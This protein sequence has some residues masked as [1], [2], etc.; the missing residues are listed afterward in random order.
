MI[1]LTKVKEK[2]ENFSLRK[3]GE[4]ERDKYF[5]PFFE[6]S[7]T[8][9]EKLLSEKTEKPGERE[10]ENLVLLFSSTLSLTT[11]HR[12]LSTEPRRS[13]FLGFRVKG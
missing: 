2:R 1:S 8:K 12:S 11:E 9:R 5:A 3:P 4:R 6:I 13:S 7:H 10:K